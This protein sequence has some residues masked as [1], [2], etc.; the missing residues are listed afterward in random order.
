LWK[1]KKVQRFEHL[2]FSGASV[3]APRLAGDARQSFATN[4]TTISTSI[5][6]SIASLLEWVL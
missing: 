3:D 1:L 5:K 4:H 6:E 2:N